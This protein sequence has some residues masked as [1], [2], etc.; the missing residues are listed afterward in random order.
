MISS[1]LSRD[2][3]HVELRDSKSILS[4][5][6]AVK[7]AEASRGRNVTLP[8]SPKI[9]AATARQISTS[10]P[11]QPFLSSMLEKPRRPWLTPQLSAPRSLT[12]LRVCATARGLPATS[13]ISSMTAVRMKRCFPKSRMHI[14]LSV[15]AHVFQLA[16]EQGLPHRRGTYQDREH[17]SYLNIDQPP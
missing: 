8:G 5:W 11:L 16:F 4:D 2:I 7:R 12:A 9:A 3:V 17:S 10:N 1:E 13:R 15:A 6:S 14:S